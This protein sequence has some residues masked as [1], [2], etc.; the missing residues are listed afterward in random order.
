MKTQDTLPISNAE[1]AQQLGVE[2]LIE[3]RLEE[4]VF[5]L[6]QAVTADPGFGRAWNDLGVVMEALGN[7]HEAMR[8]YGRA[9]TAP[10]TCREARSNLGMLTLQMSLADSL[11]RQAYC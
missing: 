9:V 10:A 1:R 11:A 5:L 8:C 2:A 4:A 6:R 3:G 7:P